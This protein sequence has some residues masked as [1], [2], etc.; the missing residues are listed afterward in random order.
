M[1]WRRLPLVAVN[2]V[3][4]IR[5]LHVSPLDSLASQSI[6]QCAL[7]LT[8][9][10][11]RGVSVRDALTSSVILRPYESVDEFSFT[12]MFCCR[13]LQL[14]DERRIDLNFY[15][16]PFN[17]LFQMLI[18][19][20]LVT[21]ACSLMMNVLIPHRIDIQPNVLPLISQLV[22]SLTKSS[23]FRSADDASIPTLPGC[24]SEQ[25]Q[26]ICDRP[27]SAVAVDLMTGF[28][29]H[30][31]DFF[32]LSQSLVEDAS[33][34]SAKSGA[35]FYEAMKTVLPLVDMFTQ[36]FNALRVA[37]SSP[38]LIDI[39]LSATA[40]TN[41][42]QVP[43]M[44][45]VILSNPVVP[46]PFAVAALVGA[47]RPNLPESL[48][49][50]SDASSPALVARYF[51]PLEDHSEL[52][53]APES[54]PTK[55]SPTDPELKL[56]EIA[57]EDETVGDDVSPSAESPINDS[58]TNELLAAINVAIRSISTGRPSQ[59]KTAGVDSI[60]K[61]FYTRVRLILRDGV[62]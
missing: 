34:V 32:T 28:M 14:A 62:L 23:Q 61:G 7:M 12:A 24:T 43:Q 52:I 20:R 48:A 27:P 17:V 15:S 1:L 41:L 5:T 37:Q 35:T 57:K 18:E 45:S 9:A 33:N 6:E 16:R 25:L 2:H 13:L 59:Y 26:L 53:K 36:W 30:R 3:H 22:E 60:Y 46:H 38:D 44:L 4:V 47:A 39:A 54:K 42:V 58:P 56:F 8:E 10:Y 40:N 50:W 49:T 51:D 11:M 21:Q 55:S 29:E 19:K 31:L